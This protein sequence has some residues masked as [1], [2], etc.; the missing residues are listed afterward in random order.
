M[1]GH[2]GRKSRLK[3]RK[4]D[5]YDYDDDDDESYDNAINMIQSSVKGHVGRKKKL[6]N[7]Q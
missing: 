1:V 6:K 4:H 5:D 2:R 3:A 7:L